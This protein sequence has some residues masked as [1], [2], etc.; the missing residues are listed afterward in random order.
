MVINAE[1]AYL[2]G[3]NGFRRVQ[4]RGDTFSV[5][6]SGLAAIYVTSLVAGSGEI[7]AGTSN[8][9]VF[10]STDEGAHWVRTGAESPLAPTNHV[11]ALLLDGSRLLAGSTDVGLYRS[12]NA[13][14]SW[15]SL[16]DRLHP[17]SMEQLLSIMGNAKA[18]WAGGPGQAFRSLDSGRT[19]NQSW[20]G[21]EDNPVASLALF[22]TLAFACTRGPSAYRG[23]LNSEEWIRIKGGPT[24]TPV[25]WNFLAVDS[26]I[27]AATTQGVYKL[28]SP[29]NDSLVPVGLADHE[30]RSLYFLAGTLFA[31]S[32]TDEGVFRSTDAGLS[33]KPSGSSFP[34]DPVKVLAAIGGDLYAATETKGIFRSVDMGSTWARGD[35]EITDNH[36]NAFAVGEKSLIAAT[37]GGIFFISKGDRIWSPASLGLSNHSISSIALFGGQA[38]ATTDGMGLW[39]RPISE[40]STPIRIK[41]AT[42]TSSPFLMTGETLHAGSKIRIE[43][44][45]SGLTDLDLYD[46]RGVHSATV[47]H[48]RLDAGQHQ[49]QFDQILS[50]GCYWLRMQSN[51]A[52]STRRIFLIP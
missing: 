16:E 49:I 29:K 43:V 37:D 31:G 13:G 12:G 3:R 25:V 1:D 50:S 46:V 18:L 21:L 35:S 24:G 9:G 14:A 41:G 6:D 8:Q 27:Y 15:V 39:T 5:L 4:L 38:F 10:R 48:G 20:R 52:S 23:S 17:R 51:G 28:A 36:V 30:I 47:F 34:K 19:W 33:W 42:L 7:F 45:N 44:A 2:G 40:I 32:A 22:D 26:V 11:N